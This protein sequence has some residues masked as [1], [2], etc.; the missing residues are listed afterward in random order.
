MKKVLIPIITVMLFITAIGF[1]QRRF[2]GSFYNPLQTS[3][4]STPK[5]ETKTISING[6]QLEVEVVTTNEGRKRGL[7]KRSSLEKDTG[8]LFVFNN[9]QRPTFWMKDMNFPID[10][11]WIDEEKIVGIDKNL[12]PES[13]IADEDLTLY[14]APQKIDYV[15]EVNAGYSDDHSLEKDNLVDLSSIN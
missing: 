2:Q 11:I 10:I 1:L 12:E 15:L 9:D 5:P 13:G 8:M 6:N 7:S 3:A 14:P 4:T